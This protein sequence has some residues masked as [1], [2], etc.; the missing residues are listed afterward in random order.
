MPDQVPES[1]GRRQILGV[2]GTDPGNRK[3][4][5]MDAEQ[6][7]QQ[8]G[9]PEGRHGK[10]DENDDGRHPVE[11]RILSDRREHPERNRHHEDEQHGKHVQEDRDRQPFENLVGN[12][13]SVH[14]KG[15]A[16]IQ[17]GQFPDPPDI[18]HGQRFVEVVHGPEALLHF[19]GGARV[20]LGLE[21]GRGTGGQVHHGKTDDRDPEQERNHEEKSL[22]DIAKHASPLTALPAR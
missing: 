13:P 6:D 16:E 21:V 19:H 22:G 17:P 11:K 8:K 4:A 5:E 3:P 20:H 10:T 2:Q 7:H 18:L 14:G 12:R 9:K 15:N 1:H